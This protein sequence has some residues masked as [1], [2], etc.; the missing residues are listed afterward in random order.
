MSSIEV[1]PIRSARERRFF[2]SFPWR[3]YG[4]DPLWVPPLLPQRAAT[5]DPERG[6]FFKR[7]EAEFFIAW[8]DGQPVG[9]ICA[10]ED[11]PTNEGRGKRECLFG[12]FECLE[13]YEVAEALLNTVRSWA[14]QRSLNALF[15][16]FNLDYEDGYGVLLEGRDRPP[17]FLCGH[18]PP[19]YRGFLERYGCEPAR[20]DNLAFA[21]DLD[22]DTPT[23]RRLF[24]LAE[25]VRQRGRITVRGADLDRW[26]DEIDR[27]HRLLNIALAHLTDH[28]GWRRDVLEAMLRPFR[29]IVDPELVLFA[30]I[31][32]ETVGWF[33]GIPNLN[34]A[35][36]H[37]NGLRYP[38]DYARLWYHM[39]SQPECL[40]IKSVLVPPEYWGRGVAVVLFAEMGKR[41]KARGFKWLDLSL[42]SADNPNTPILAER[43]GAKVYKRYRVYRRW[44]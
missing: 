44:V 15:G 43:M 16:P 27:V 41:A 17:V 26:D 28:I 12:F 37:A 23:A 19:Y 35:F 33:P 40:A 1:R 3:I 8:R 7:G 30:E 36:I 32:G 5:I 6:L 24:R 39:R 38:W 18:T 14:K 2:L 25:R 10:A 4:D 21:I 11:P 42:T 22:L 20:A 9:T 29:D 34:E 13:E 31:D